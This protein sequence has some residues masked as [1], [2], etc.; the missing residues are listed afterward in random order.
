MMNW[1]WTEGDLRFMKRPE[2]E[3]ALGE[4]EEIVPD[5]GPVLGQDPAPEGEDLDP[6]LIQEGALNPD[7]TQ[8][9]V[10]NPNHDPP[11]REEEIDLDPGQHLDLRIPI[12]KR[13]EIDPHLGRRM[14]HG[15]DRALALGHD[16]DPEATKSS[17]HSSWRIP[18]E[19]HQLLF[20]DI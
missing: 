16:P 15:L 2:E 5:L 3:E 6:D 8:E 4:V 12:E 9:I 11:E 13:M 1:N 20:T 19:Y 18:I 14:H 7:R 17:A 10:P